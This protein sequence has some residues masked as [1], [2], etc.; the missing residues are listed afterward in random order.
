VASRDELQKRH[1]AIVELGLKVW[2]W[3]EQRRLE[4]TFAS[5]QEYALCPHDKCPETNPSRNIL[6]NIKLGGPRV[7]LRS[8]CW[9]HPRSHAL[10]ALSLLLWAPQV[11]PPS[12]FTRQ[13]AAYKARW[14]QVN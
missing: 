2:L 7:L 13:V 6:V 9:R 8:D 14:K 10:C 5:A 3:Q 1:A 11:I 12:V 4:H